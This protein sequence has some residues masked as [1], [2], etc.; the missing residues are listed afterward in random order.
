MRRPVPLT[1]LHYGK[2]RVDCGCWR[3]TDEDEY[4][5]QEELEQSCDAEI[6][7]EAEQVPCPRADAPSPESRVKRD[8]F[9]G[10]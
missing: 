2:C 9:S 1:Q 8:Q 7:D 4:G 5:S 6:L 3:L 10:A